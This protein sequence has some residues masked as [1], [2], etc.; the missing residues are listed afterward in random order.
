MHE[1]VTGNSSIR[2]NLGGS[3][4]PGNQTEADSMKAMHQL[5]L[6][7]QFNERLKKDRAEKGR[8]HL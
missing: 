8:H 5:A 1:A 3:G 2:R 4:P 6:S 7:P